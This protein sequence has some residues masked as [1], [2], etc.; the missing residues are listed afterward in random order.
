MS[1]SMHGQEDN[2]G[3]RYCKE[4]GVHGYLYPCEHYL[5]DILEEIKRKSVGL[6]SF[7]DMV[8]EIAVKHFGIKDE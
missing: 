2:E 5:S 8:A 6:K 7:P 3:C 4:H 1:D